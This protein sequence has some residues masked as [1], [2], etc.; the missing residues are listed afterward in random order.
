MHA[1]LL[2]PLAVTS[3]NALM[4]RMGRRW[5]SLHRLGTDHPLGCGTYGGGQEGNP[6]ALLRGSYH[7]DACGLLAVQQVPRR[8]SSGKY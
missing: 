2:I 6:R 1:V 8:H 3:T 4:R 5:T 7:L